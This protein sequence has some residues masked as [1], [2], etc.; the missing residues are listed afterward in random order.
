MPAAIVHLV[1]HGEV[2]NPRRIRYGRL[3]GYRLSARGRDQALA[4]ARHLEAVP[5]VVL[6]ASPLERAVETAEIIARHLRLGEVARDERLLE[7]TTV[8]EGQPKTAPAL[9][10]NWPRL[11]NP[12]R[13]SWGEPFA[14]VRT[15][16]LA[17]IAD[18]RARHPGRTVV[19]VSHQSPIWITRQAL[20][21]VNP[22]WCGRVRCGLASVH[23]LHFDGPGDRY[24][25]HRY[26]AP[27]T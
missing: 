9:P 18:L 19:A 8:F 27:P 26:W 20:E 3:P 24:T 7:T 6:Y 12:F 15:R 16:M 10:W 23:A 11:W 2:D 14:Q 21:Q 25:G 1:R 17:A 13:P 4:A 22:P 5:D